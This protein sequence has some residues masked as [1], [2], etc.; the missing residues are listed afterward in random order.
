MP[1]TVPDRYGVV[2]QSFHWLTAVLVLVAFTLGPGGPED[3]VY[4]AARDADRQLHESLGLAVFV[5]VVLRSIWRMLDEHPDPPP[6]SRWM[7]LAAR[8]TQAALYVLLFA[9]PLTAIT[10]AWL[11]GHPLTLVAGLRVAPWLPT[12]HGIGATLAEVHG[13]LG[14]VLLWVAGL[15]ALAALY[16]HVMLKDGVLVSMLPRWMARSRP[17]VPAPSDRL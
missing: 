17:D 6:V 2:A 4:A 8:A 9:V 16:H 3:R 12:S 14:D 13:W 7:G 11:G 1:R 15:H 10:G 5:L